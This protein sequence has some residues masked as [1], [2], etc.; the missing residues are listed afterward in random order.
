MEKTIKLEIELTEEEYT[1]LL[2]SVD[3]KLD[4]YNK[5]KSNRFVQSAKDANNILLKIKDACRISMRNEE[6]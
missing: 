2:L 3:D 6:K 5:Y 1:I 4:F